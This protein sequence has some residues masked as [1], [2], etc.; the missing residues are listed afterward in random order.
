MVRAL[1]RPGHPW[2]VI[3]VRALRFQWSKA[4]RTPARLCSG[5]SSRKIFVAAEVITVLAAAGR[6]P[7]TTHPR[8][9]DDDM[10]R[11]QPLQAAGCFYG[12]RRSVSSDGPNLGRCC[13]ALALLFF[14]GSRSPVLAG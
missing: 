11:S 10:Q 8:L 2:L 3:G 4:P 6:C 5:S 9:R 7:Q 12:T 1:G 14:Y 13:N